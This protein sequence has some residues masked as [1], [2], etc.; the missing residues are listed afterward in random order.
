MTI[1]PRIENL[2]N[3]KEVEEFFEI[4]SKQFII[5]EETGNE[6]PEEDE[7]TN[8]YQCFIILEKAIKPSRFKTRVNVQFKFDLDEDQNKSAVCVR[9]VKEE[10]IQYVEGYTLK[11]GRTVYSQGY[12]DQELD[13]SSKVYQKGKDAKGKK[14]NRTFVSDFVY[15]MI[16]YG[17]KNY[18]LTDQHHS[19]CPDGKPI[20][21]N[22]AQLLTDYVRHIGY[23]KVPYSMYS[24]INITTLEHYI[25]D[26]DVFFVKDHH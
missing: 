17:I 26:T 9:P 15:G 22:T 21:K 18:P 11:E 7:D 8:H 16:E 25:H 5:A 4:Y 19:G 1:R 20:V 24:K 14:S 10:D 23:K 13:Q 12:T 3:V 6:N 2:P